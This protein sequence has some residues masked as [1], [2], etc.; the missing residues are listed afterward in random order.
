MPRNGAGTYTAPAST[1][2]P[3]VNGVTATT[4]D[5][6][7]LL[8]DMSAAITQSVSSDGQTPMTGNLPMGNNKITGLATGTASTDA[9]NLSQVNSNAGQCRLL[10]SGANLVL[11]PYQGN[12]LTINGVV[13]T[14]PS[15]GVSLAPAGATPSTLYY[16]YAYMVGAVMTLEYSVTGHS[17]DTTTGVEIKTGD[18]TRTLVGMAYPVT[19]PAWSDTGVQRYVLSWFNRRE[20]DMT[21]GLPANQANGNTSYVELLAAAKNEF[22]TWSGGIVRM[23]VTGGV[24]NST[25]L[26]YNYTSVGIDGATTQDSFSIFQG[27]AVSQA[28]PISVSTTNSGLSE[29]KHYMNII[30][31]VSTGTGT[32]IG[33][34]A[35]ART[36]ISGSTWG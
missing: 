26:A 25:A 36:S 10:K 28:G 18:A 29:G 12:R 11:Q 21:N 27:T 1:W 31:Q 20:L 14:I 30:G 23:A 2:N 3:G 4:A 19:G 15:G 24:Q 9:V 13:Y 7:A 16:I 33:G 34:A 35:G 22:L 6:N 32:W 5:F 8:T 17:T